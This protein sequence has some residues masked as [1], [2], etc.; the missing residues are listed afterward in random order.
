MLKYSITAT[1]K[2]L[3]KETGKEKG[4]NYIAQMHKNKNGYILKIYIGNELVAEKNFEKYI[5]KNDLIKDL[6]QKYKLKFG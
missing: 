3:N 6:N 5:I 4:I 2:K 1:K